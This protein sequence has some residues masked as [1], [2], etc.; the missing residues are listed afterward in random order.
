SS[1]A[2][3]SGA[4]GRVD[5]PPIS[6][7]S[8]PSA[9]MPSA[10]ATAVSGSSRTPPSEKESGVTLTMPTTNVRR[11]SS[12]TRPSGRGT[13]NAARVICLLLH[14]G[15]AERRHDGRALGGLAARLAVG[16]RRA[17]ARGPG[18]LGQRQALR[19]PLD[20]L[21]VE[22]LAREQL[23]GDGQQ[24]CLVRDE[25]VARPLVVL[26]D[27]LL[28]FLIDADGR[29]LAVVLRLR[30]L[31]AEEDL[32][33]TLAE[34]ERAH[35]IAHAPLA[36]HLARQVGDPLEVVAGARRLLARGDFLGN[37]AAEQDGQLIDQVVARIV[38]L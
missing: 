2:E 10:S 24:R 13:L 18:R 5:S 9:T 36:D 8:A 35:R 29:V 27:Q 33:F 14:D 31:A 16:R 38:V 1:E 34:R 30:E 11:P 23:V 32:L 3:T 22:D 19:E 20:L 26:H 4:P 21:G 25:Q 12:R 7:M 28:D 15:L 37:A 6:R 17:A